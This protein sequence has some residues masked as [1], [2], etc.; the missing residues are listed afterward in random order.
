MHSSFEGIKSEQKRIKKQQNI[1][2]ETVDLHRDGASLGLSVV[3]GSDLV[4]HPF[5]VDTPGVFISKV[6]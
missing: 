3:G 6:L 2:M 4:S 1:Q 5:G